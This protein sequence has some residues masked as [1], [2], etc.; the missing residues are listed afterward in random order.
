MLLKKTYIEKLHD[1]KSDEGD[2]QSNND[3]NRNM[4]RLNNRSLINKNS[5]SVPL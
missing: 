4:Y 3:S 5:T 2:I 1:Q